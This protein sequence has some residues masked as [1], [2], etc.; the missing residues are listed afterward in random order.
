MVD[1][2]AAQR[3][4]VVT[5]TNQLF[6]VRGEIEGLEQMRNDLAQEV[7]K[8][9]K[10]MK[11]YGLKNTALTDH[12]PRKLKGVVTG[13]RN[14]MIVVSLG[15]DDGLL[16]GHKLDIYRTTNNESVYVG[17]ARVSTVLNDSASAVIDA[18]YL[19]RRMMEGDYVTTEF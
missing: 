7:A 11:A 2:I 6:K 18:D 10:V 14:N 12:I 1:N 15:K 4:K 3:T 13:V 9:E 8:N 19:K 5:L 17:Q 16:E